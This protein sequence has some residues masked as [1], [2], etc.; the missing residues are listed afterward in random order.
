MRR[1]S[2]LHMHYGPG[3]MQA[4]ALDAADTNLL[5]QYPQQL[6]ELGLGLDERAILNM[7]KNDARASA[8]MDSA[9]TPSMTAPSIATPVQF[10][11]NWLPGAVQIIT[12]P[13]VIDDLVGITIQGSWED[14][15]IVQRV[16]EHKSQAQ[17]YGDFTDVPFTS[18]NMQFE[19]RTVV[20]FEEGLR[21]SKLEEARAARMQVNSAQEKRTAAMESLE[22]ERNRVGFNG[23]NG[24]ANRTYGMLNDVDLP[25]YVTLPNGASNDSKFSTK[26][27]LEMT[28]DLS[29]MASTLRAQS[30]GR[31]DPNKTRCILAV[32]LDVYDPL[33]STTTDHGMSVLDWMKKTYPNWE[34][35]PVPEF[36][37]ANGGESVLYLYAA[38]VDDSGTDDQATFVQVVPTKFQSLG[39]DQRVKGYEEGFTNATAGVM[40]KRPY[41]VVRFTG[42]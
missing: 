27:Y 18:W 15:E 12:A 20:R 26:T 11:Q 37:D 30:G 2:T 38:N 1:R 35:M 28:S 14:E 31:V 40:T 25:V 10:L 19:R 16:M 42:A 41:A 7:I 6:V 36:K 24:G 39:T 22:I 4:I 34:A 9:L 13:R 32:A 29:L 3:Q 33:I 23:F 5:A 17:V 8:A 21:V